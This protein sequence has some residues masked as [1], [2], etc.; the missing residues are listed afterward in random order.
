MVRVSSST[1]A[2]P[3]GGVPVT[4]AV[5]WIDPASTCSW[6]TVSVAVKVAV[7]PGNSVPCA[8][9]F[10]FDCQLTAERSGNGSLTDTA[11]SVTLPVFL[12]SKV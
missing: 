5:F 4:E 1:T 8:E 11:V 9:P 6:V 12:A 7:S 2:G 10:E 3:L